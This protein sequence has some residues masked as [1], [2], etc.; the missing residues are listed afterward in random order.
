MVQENPIRGRSCSTIAGNTIAP[1][2]EPAAPTAKAKLLFVVKYVLSKLIAGQNRNPLPRPTHTP[3]A[4]RSCQY[5]V[6]KEAI[7]IPTTHTTLPVM[8]TG[9][10]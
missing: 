5:C 2:A 7:K 4:R 3:C 8:S 1:V 9:R 6:D 10:K